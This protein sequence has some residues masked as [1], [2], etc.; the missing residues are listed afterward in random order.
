MFTLFLA[1]LGFFQYSISS[2]D[3]HIKKTP[4]I[5]SIAPKPSPIAIEYGSGFGGSKMGKFD[6]VERI[7]TV[8]SNWP[9]LMIKAKRMPIAVITI[10]RANFVVFLVMLLCCP[11]SNTH[12]IK[13]YFNLICRTVSLRARVS[14]RDVRCLL[15]S[16]R[17]PNFFQKFLFLKRVFLQIGLLPNNRSIDVA[18]YSFAIVCI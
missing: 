17:K 18:K 10:P 16:N 6:E 5:T 14:P 4:T 15:L 13:R 8:V 7:G 2:L 3:F 12:H 11:I 1:S 9:T